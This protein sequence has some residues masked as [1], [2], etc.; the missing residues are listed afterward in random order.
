MSIDKSREDDM[1]LEEL[2]S[3]NIKGFTDR[4]KLAI[5]ELAEQNQG[6]LIF[7]VLSLNSRIRDLEETLLG[8]RQE[9]TEH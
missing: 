1:V 3:Q 7:L 6:A 9:A 2:K 5:V 4:G 8:I